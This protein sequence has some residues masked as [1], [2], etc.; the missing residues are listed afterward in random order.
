MY[1]IIRCRSPTGRSPRKRTSVALQLIICSSCLASQPDMQHAIEELQA[2]LGNQLDIT[3]LD[4]MA[5]CDDVP[6]V[7]IEH[8][9]C[10]RLSPHSLRRR[11]LDAIDKAPVT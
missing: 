8:A 6:A 4:C 1:I 9:Y 10:P 3:R 11:I 5:A 2:E 7:M